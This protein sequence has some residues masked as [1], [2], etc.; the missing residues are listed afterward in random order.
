MAAAKK[1]DLK[2]KFE[3]GAVAAKETKKKA[4]NATLVTL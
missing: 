3:A 1:D 4:A 2:A